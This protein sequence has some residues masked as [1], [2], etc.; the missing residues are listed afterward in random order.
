MAPTRSLA[1]ASYYYALLLHITSSSSIWLFK[2]PNLK[3]IEAIYPTMTQNEQYKVEWDKGTFSH[4]V[5]LLHL[6]VA[7]F[8][9]VSQSATDWQDVNRTRYGRWKLLSLSWTWTWILA[10]C[11][12]LSSLL[13]GSGCSSAGDGSHSLDWHGTHTL[14]ADMKRECIWAGIY[15]PVCFSS[16]GHARCA[17][18]LGLLRLAHS[19]MQSHTSRKD[20]LS[21]PAVALHWKLQNAGCLDGQYE[22]IWAF[23]VAYSET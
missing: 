7:M 12:V 1:H 3:I 19:G 9:V 22:S 10:L 8:T 20:S 13:T 18:L 16:F 2:T 11:R 17:C 23:Q 21:A 15:S 14:I 5:L 4:N 6:Q